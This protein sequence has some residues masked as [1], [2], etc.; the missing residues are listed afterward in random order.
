MIFHIE[1]YW[2]D[3]PSTLKVRNVV[4]PLPVVICF[5]TPQF[6]SSI[7]ISTHYKPQHYNLYKI[8]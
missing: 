1:L 7:S 8:L 5:E 4:P 3:T 6:T 2:I